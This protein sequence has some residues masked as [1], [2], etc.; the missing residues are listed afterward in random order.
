[1]GRPCNTPSRLFTD[2]L[3]YCRQGWRSSPPPF[4]CRRDMSDFSRWLRRADSY[5]SVLN[6]WLWAPFA[7]CLLRKAWVLS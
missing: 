4:S 3:L 7:N 5:F 6:I 2:S 1:M